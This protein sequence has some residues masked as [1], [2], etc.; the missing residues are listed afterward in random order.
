M[1]CARCGREGS[2]G[3]ET[4]GERL[5]CRARP[6][7]NERIAA[8]ARRT[9]I[10]RSEWQGKDG[11]WTH[12]YR[13]DGERVGGVT[14]LIKEGLP[15]PALVGWGIN[16]VSR[17]AAEHIDEL[18]A[19]RGMGFEAMFQALRQSPYKQR[20]DA[21]AR[22]TQ[23]H[24]W[25]EMLAVG[26]IADV[27][28]DMLPWVESLRDYLDDF[29]PESRMRELP[30]G[31]RRWRYGGTID[32]LSVFRGARLSGDLPVNCTQQGCRHELRIVDYKSGNGV[33]PDSALQ[34]AAYKHAEIY[35]D[36]D[37]QERRLADLGICDE[38]YIV[39]VRPEGYAVVPF[40]IGP[41]VHQAF[42]RV[43]WLARLRADDG[44]LR[45]WMGEPFRV[46]R[47]ETRER[48]A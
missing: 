4:E 8:V 7:C 3:F 44:A 2:R 23:L 29:Q 43:A 5:V 39:H 37:G 1:I 17:Y 9:S 26:D 28:V 20:N 22:G 36:E 11:R 16:A 12:S 15:T 41:E 10:Y 25:A 33:Y 30:V 47:Q 27:P 32:D 13:L 19:M 18:W 34:L 46:A 38:G 48:S 35:K 31:S 45:T 24:R 40:Y 21:G 14:T 42:G 6:A